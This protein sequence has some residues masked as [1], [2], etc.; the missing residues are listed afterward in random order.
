MVL[1]WCTPSLISRHCASHL[2]E[3]IRW[4][5]TARTA[6]VIQYESENFTYFHNAL[7]YTDKLII[8]GASF[9]IKLNGVGLGV[10]QSH[11]L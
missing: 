4:G 3:Y 10:S 7:G 5:F 2:V 1:P 11:R 6:L 9:D 8:L